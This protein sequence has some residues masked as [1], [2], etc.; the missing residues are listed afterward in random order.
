MNYGIKLWYDRH[1]LLMGDDR[2]EKNLNEGVRKCSHA[3]VVLSKDTEFS[4]CAMEEIDIIRDKLLKGSLTIFP[5][6]YELSPDNI[7]NNLE[8]IKKLIFKEVNRYSGTLEVCNHIACRITDEILNNCCYQNIS[9]IL[10]QSGKMLQ[11]AIYH[12]LYS[13]QQI[14]YENLNS[15][16]TLLYSIYL[17]VVKSENLQSNSIT[18]ML[19]K[20][21]DRLFAET[22]LNLAIDYRELWLL[23]NSICILINYYITSCIESNI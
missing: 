13:Y 16:I 21:F 8:W 4:K 12:L 23:E 9:E 20:I 5:I 6:L 14:S 17:I 10:S 15:R 3:L 7:P 22:Q 19:S 1:R 2:I 11:P 18:D